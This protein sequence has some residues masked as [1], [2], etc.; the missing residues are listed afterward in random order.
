MSCSPPPSRA[1]RWPRWAAWRSGTA[2]SWR[3]S[4]PRRRSSA[5]T[6]T[7][8]SAPAWTTCWPAAQARARGQG[9]AQAAPRHPRRTALPPRPTVGAARARRGTGPGVPPPAGHGAGGARSRSLPAATGAARSARS[10]RSAARSSPARRRD[11]GRGPVAG[12]PAACASCCWSAR[13]P[14]PTA[15]TWATCGCSRSCC[16]SWRRSTASTRVRI[17]YLQPAELRPGLIDVDRR[18]PGCGALLRPVVPARQRRRAA[19]DAPVRRPG[20]RSC[21]LLDQIRERVPR[22]GRAVQLHRRLPRRDRGRPEGARTVPRQRRGSTPSASSATP[23]RTAPRPRRCGGKLDQAEIARR[24]EDF[25][26][27]A[28]ELMGQRA[29]DRV[30]ETVEVLVEVGS[31]DGRGGPGRASGARGGR[32]HHAGA[33]VRRRIDGRRRDARRRRRDLARDGGRLRR[34]ST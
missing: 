22:G 32:H 12:R 10:R 1:P 17:S 34:A 21:G 5:S 27:L 25:A 6:T 15:R 33:A 18:H 9:P 23:T 29:A 26:D 30:G 4:C 11:A 28:E 24:V 16:P 31:G 19:R 20:A 3:R 7:P 13:T 2:P 8:T 14:P